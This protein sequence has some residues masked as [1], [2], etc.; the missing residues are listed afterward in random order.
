MLMQRYKIIADQAPAPQYYITQLLPKKTGDVH[1]DPDIKKLSR[2][3]PLLMRLSP[4]LVIVFFLP[5]MFMYSFFIIHGFFYKTLL[6]FLFLFV[7]GNL[8]YLDVALWKYYR[9]RR[10]IRI[11]LIELVCISLVVFFFL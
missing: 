10:K 2:R 5:L 6:F 11:W 1:I 3:V 7:E 4:F 8:F 9:G